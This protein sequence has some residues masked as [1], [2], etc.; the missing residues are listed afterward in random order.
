MSVDKISLDQPTKKTDSEEL[1]L[2]HHAAP[3]D[4]THSLAEHAM[5]DPHPGHDRHAGHSVAMFRDK[6]WWTLSLTIPSVAW[7]ADIQ[8]WLD[9]TAP[10]FPGSK[11]IP[12][13]FGTIVFAYGGIVFLRGA[14]GEL[15]DRKPG[16]MTLINLGILV[17][18]GASLSAAFGLFEVEVWWELSTLITIMVLGHW[19]EMRAIAQV[20]GALNALASLL[21]DTAERVDG[22]EIR[23]IPIGSCA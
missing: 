23:T 16:M 18:I 21:P 15:A 22:S 17:A 13:I 5:K 7:S 20:H 4:S 11:W 8:L 3:L 14:R 2:V 12:A 19:M 10:T 6:F 9:Y 1:E